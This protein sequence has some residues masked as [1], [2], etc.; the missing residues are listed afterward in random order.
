MLAIAAS[1]ITLFLFAFKLCEY[2]ESE[3]IKALERIN[4]L[5]SWRN[6]V[7]SIK[8]EVADAVNSY[9]YLIEIYNNYRLLW[10]LIPNLLLAISIIAA[11]PYAIS[12]FNNPPL[13]VPWIF[14][15]LLGTVIP[16][17][18][19]IMAVT[20][21]PTRKYL[22]VKRRYMERTRSSKAVRYTE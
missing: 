11:V 20:K 19:M 4:E 10:I 8:G 1:V 22:E 6:E 16:L 17:I 15:Y 7:N 18:G 9:E 5:E 2:F 13:L 3:T 14:F 21:Q 12:F